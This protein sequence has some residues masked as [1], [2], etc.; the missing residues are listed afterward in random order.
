LGD[1]PAAHERDACLVWLEQFV[2]DQVSPLVQPALRR[3]A[4]MAAALS[5]TARVSGDRV[6]L[7]GTGG[8]T[9]IL[10][11]IEAGLD[12]F[13]RDMIEGQH[14]SRDRVIWHRDR[15]W[16]LPLAERRKIVGLP[17][18]RADV[19]LAGVAIYAA[20]MSV[21][22]FPELRVSTRGLRF[23]GVMRDTS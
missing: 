17:S 16:S 12:T 23:A 20:V 7:V 9:T 21:F 4:H 1:P 19:I 5:A 6:L 10:A 22:E 8:T 11:R 18:N 15:L 3:L 2:R 13:D 14:L